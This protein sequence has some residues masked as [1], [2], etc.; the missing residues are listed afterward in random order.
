MV[1]HHWATNHNWHRSRAKRPAQYGLG[2]ARGSTANIGGGGVGGT[3]KI[4][5]SPEIYTV[6]AA[7]GPILQKFG[8]LMSSTANGT[9]RPDS[10]M[11]LD[12]ISGSA[13]VQDSPDRKNEST[14]LKTACG[15]RKL[16]VVRSY[17]DLVDAFRRRVTELDTDYEEVD[18]VAGYTDTYTSK[19]LAPRPSRN[20]GEVSLGSMLGALGLELHVIENPDATEKA[21]A[22]LKKRVFKNTVHASGKHYVSFRLSL[23]SLQ[24]NARKGGR[25]RAQKLTAARRREIASNAA[26]KRW[27]RPKIEDVTPVG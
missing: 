17:Y 16:A 22:R 9:A 27:H 18:R 1:Y 7:N 3:S 2:D 4:D 26:K 10:E 5:R 6:P 19:L 11:R 24:R 13:G 21:K 25:A 12:S 20:F 23:R 14:S 15:G 8:A